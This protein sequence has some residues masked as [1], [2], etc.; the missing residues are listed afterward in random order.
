[1]SDTMDAISARSEIYEPAP[2]VVAAANVPDYLALRPQ[3]IEDPVA[4]WDARAK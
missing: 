3:A 4:F 1:M 2:H